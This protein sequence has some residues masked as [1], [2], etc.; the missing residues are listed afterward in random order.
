MITGRYALAGWVAIAQAVL[1][2]PAIGLALFFDGASGRSQ[3]GLLLAAL[4]HVLAMAA[5][6]YVLL[7]F[8]SLLHELEDF[9]TTDLLITLFIWINVASA[10]LGILG[11]ALQSPSLPPAWAVACAVLAGV[12]LAG[13][14]VVS[15]VFGRRLLSMK[16]DLGGLLKPFAYT[17]VA[18]GTL[19]LT[20]VGAPIGLALALAAIVMQG[21]ILLRANEDLQYV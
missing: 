13:H 10:G 1:F 11:L 7:A 2:F 20:V 15:I 5:G 6:V 9:R 3:G 12:L 4:L 8:R 17:T 19:V 21:M 14:G 18:S 16:D